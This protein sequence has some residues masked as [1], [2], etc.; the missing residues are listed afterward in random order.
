[1]QDDEHDGATVVGDKGPSEPAI[2]LSLLLSVLKQDPYYSNPSPYYGNRSPYYGQQPYSAAYNPFY[3][4]QQ[5][6]YNPFF[7]PYQQYQQ[8]QIKDQQQ[9]D[10]LSLLMKNALFASRPS[11]SNDHAD[12]S[13]AQLDALIEHL[14]AEDS[15][16]PAEARKITKKIK[17]ILKYI[18]TLG[19]LP[20]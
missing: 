17:N 9:S 14:A 2:P 7:N 12:G 8:P 18:F 10:M 11:S 3:G 5:P 1:M 13:S 6:Q 20:G 15:S 16:S 4:Y 19:L